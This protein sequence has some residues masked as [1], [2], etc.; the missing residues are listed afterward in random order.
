MPALSNRGPST[1]IGAG[2]ALGRGVTQNRL[3]P[4]FKG[5][6]R[7]RFYDTHQRGRGVI[8]RERFSMTPSTK[9]SRYGYYRF[10]VSCH[11]RND[12]E[13]VVVVGSSRYERGG[14]CCTS[15]VKQGEMRTTG[16]DDWAVG[17]GVM[18]REFSRKTRRI[19]ARGLCGG[20][21]AGAEDTE[22]QVAFGSNDR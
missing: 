6:T 18:K 16:R 19:S 20:G 11:P 5:G 13:V 9:M 12:G 15:H 2:G 21:G 3:R 10:A 14:R 4:Q 8:V 1:N 7:F 17:V 22:K